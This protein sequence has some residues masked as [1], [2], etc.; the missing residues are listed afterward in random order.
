MFNPLHLKNTFLNA[1]LINKLKFCYQP[2][3]K[4]SV[5]KSYVFHKS[6]HSLPNHALKSRNTRESIEEMM[7]VNT[8]VQNNVLLFKHESS[9]TC[10]LLRYFSIGWVFCSA[11]LIYYSYNQINLSE[12]SKS[13]SRKDYLNKK[14]LYVVMFACGIV[15]GPLAIFI[16]HF[17]M[18]RFIKYIILNRGGKNVSLITYHLFKKEALLTLPVNMVKSS[19]SRQEAKQYLPLKVCDK[20]FFYLMDLEGTMLNEKLFDNTIGYDKVFQHSAFTNKK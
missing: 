18:Q 5:H 4:N 20:L 10:T 11:S 9:T 3:V 1:S 13:I 17:S 2:V 19:M 15:L 7:N 12:Y 6:Y 16:L 8:N 14:G